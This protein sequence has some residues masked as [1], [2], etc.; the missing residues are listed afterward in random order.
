MDE[1]EIDEVPGQRAESRMIHA[2]GSLY[3]DPRRGCR[4]KLT[5]DEDGV[6]VSSEPHTGHQ[7]DPQLLQE[8]LFLNECKSR[9]R[10][11]LEAFRDIFDAV[12]REMNYPGASWES[13]RRKMEYARSQVIPRTPRRL[14]EV[15]ERLE[16]YE[17]MRGFYRGAMRLAN[18]A[19]AVIFILTAMLPYL[20]E[21]TVLEAD[22]TFR[23]VSTMPVMKQLYTIHITLFGK[24]I[25]G[26]F[27]L[28][29][30]M[31]E[32]MYTEILRAV[33]RIVPALRNNVISVMLDFERAAM[34]AFSTVF[35]NMILSGCY[36][37]YV[38]AVMK[39]FYKLEI[40]EGGVVRILKITEAIPFL[41]V[42]KIE[43]GFDY[44][45]REAL[46]F[47]DPKINQFV[48]YLNFWR[49]LAGV[50]SVHRKRIKTNNGQ[51]NF[52]MRMNRRIQIHCRFWKL[53]DELKNAATDAYYSLVRVEAGRGGRAPVGQRQRDY[54]NRLTEL[55]DSLDAN[56]P[57]DV[58]RYLED[59][60][61]FRRQFGHNAQNVVVAVPDNAEGADEAALSDDENLD[62][63]VKDRQAQELVEDIQIHMQAG[64]GADAEAVE[65][66]AGQRRRC[67][68]IQ[69]A[70]PLLDKQNPVPRQGQRRPR[71]PEP[72]VR[73]LR[74]RM[75]RNG[76]GGVQNEEVGVEQ[77]AQLDPSPLMIAEERPN[78]APQV[79]NVDVA[80]KC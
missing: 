8:E 14:N 76:N 58:P 29:N 9:A 13:A 56:D 2:R 42:A 26:I 38:R 66:D 31:Q 19:C 10:H 36:F 67:R 12:S 34:N 63:E 47:R 28:T 35:E 32:I 3:Y 43:Q 30:S 16:G 11:T 15:P 24:S 64:P 5:I 68:R 4:G 69:V 21:A 22:G 51:E 65:N 59:V 80:G 79:A 40:R 72:N 53:L 61:V 71:T 17:R 70:V 49:R 33:V 44:L 55:E 18:G 39:K 73:Q 74:P 6:L 41:P 25:S 57:L 62:P 60:M 37:H 48:R 46:Q 50:I 27:V 23:C 45:N 7:A 54:N 20:N 1:I 75:D 78:E 77:Q 52:H